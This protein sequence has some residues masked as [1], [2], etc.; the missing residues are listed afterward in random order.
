MRG[1]AGANLRSSSLSDTPRN[2]HQP[3]PFLVITTGIY[4]QIRRRPLWIPVRWG[5]R[6]FQD[7]YGATWVASVRER[8]EDDYKGRY[9]F[10][11]I[12]EGGATDCQFG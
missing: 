9:W 10:V 2:F 6:D 11:M 5:M 3:P 4:E 1:V 8:S 12:P 7:E